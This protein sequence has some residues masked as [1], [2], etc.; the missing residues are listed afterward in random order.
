MKKSLLFLCI[1]TIPALLLNTPVYAAALATET[2]DSSLNLWSG[3]V[4]WTDVVQHRPTGG[5]PGGYMYIEGK[6]DP[7]AQPSAFT[8]ASTDFIGDYSAIP[9]TQV[10]FDLNLYE[11][12]LT[13]TWLRF[14]YLDATQNGWHYVLPVSPLIEE[15][16][17]SFTVTLDPF[18]TDLEA[19][20]AGW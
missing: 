13:E 17:V 15:D 9:I 8:S 10:S 5:N 14:R 11:G 6:A 19:G 3:N 4:A 12:E 2:W 7:S 1:F 20:A 16:W 18:W